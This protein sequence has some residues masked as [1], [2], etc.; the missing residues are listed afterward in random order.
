MRL[1]NLDEALRM[2][3]TSKIDCPFDSAPPMF[4]WQQAHDCA[5]SCVEAV[6]AIN[7]VPV[8]AVAQMF[9]DFTGD[10]CPC[11]FNDND[12]WLPLVC[13]YEA[14]GKC[15]DPDDMLGC[16]KQYIKHYGERKDGDG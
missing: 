3:K 15:P 10:K 6:P 14:E 7:A 8:E 5:I 9:L 12:E 4:A 11:N 16:W 13:E 1:G 2:I